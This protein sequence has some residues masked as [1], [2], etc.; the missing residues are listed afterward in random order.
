[1]NASLS[2]FK[3]NNQSIT[4]EEKRGYY[5]VGKIWNDDSF[6]CSFKESADLSILENIILPEC[7]NGK[8]GRVGKGQVS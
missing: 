8:W 7:G 1:M 4:I 5:K 6:I 2:I 3:Q